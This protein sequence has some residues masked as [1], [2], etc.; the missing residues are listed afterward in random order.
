MIGGEDEI[1]LITPH[2]PIGYVLV[3]KE[4]ALTR[5]KSGGPDHV[6]VD[7][8]EEEIQAQED[9]V[10]PPVILPTLPVGY[11]VVDRSGDLVRVT[12]GPPDHVF[13]DDEDEDEQTK[14]SKEHLPVIKPHVSVCY[15]V[16]DQSG[17][18]SRIKAGPPDHVFTDEEDVLEGNKEPSY[19]KPPAVITPRLH[20]GY[21]VVDRSGDLIRIQSDHYPTYVFSSDEEDPE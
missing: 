2:L 19:T 20:I 16:V 10:P 5:I 11:N 7:D 9:T 1:P 12:F 17:N 13:T 6:F 3:D 8:D 15:S 14:G 4:G 18:L 21:K